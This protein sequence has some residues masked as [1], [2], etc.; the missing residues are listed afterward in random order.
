MMSIGFK[1][2]FFA[3]LFEAFGLLEAEDCEIDCA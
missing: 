3:A 2:D 1:E